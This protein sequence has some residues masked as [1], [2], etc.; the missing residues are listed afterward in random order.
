VTKPATTG[1]RPAYEG[2]AD[3]LREQILSGALQPGDQLPVEP[4]LSEIHSVSRSTVREALRL[5]SSQNLV[6]TTRGVKGG[7]FVVQP[8][9]SHISTFLKASLGLLTSASGSVND[10]LEVRALLEVPAAGLAARRRTAEQLEE[11][12]RSLFDPRE[13]DVQRMFAANH[14]FHVALLRAAGNPPLEAVT[15]PVFGILQDR[16]HREEAPARFWTQVDR[17]HREIYGYVQG[18]DAAGASQAQAEHL[19]RL[20]STYGRIDR[21]RRKA[22]PDAG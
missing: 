14:N 21:E 1:G 9:P 10:L 12:G 18:R 15:R 2:L 8:D 16:F 19:K 6:T 4:Q 22:T 7:S 13:I 11:L 17:D 20:R 3:V 5:L